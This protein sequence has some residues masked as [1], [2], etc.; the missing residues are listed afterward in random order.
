MNY[1]LVEKT[2]YE[3]HISRR[4]LAKM[5]DLSPATVNAAMKRKAKGGVL[6]SVNTLRK[7]SK[8]L[9][10][11]LYEIM[12]NDEIRNEIGKLPEGEPLQNIGKEASE[13]PN[14]SYS[15]NFIPKNYILVGIEREL[16][17]SLG[18]NLLKNYYRQLNKQGRENLV[19]IA[20]SMTLAPIYT[21]EPEDK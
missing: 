10:I 5:L 14:P 1:A 15:D 8:I 16:A 9:N 11:D 20:E 18:F 19:K 7:L 2:M 17:E 21:K 6:N 12:L 3:K 13:Q 4:Q